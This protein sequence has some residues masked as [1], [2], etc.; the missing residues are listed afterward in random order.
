MMKVQQ[1]NFKEPSIAKNHMKFFLM[2]TKI[3]NGI[4]DT[5]QYEDK[6]INSLLINQVIWGT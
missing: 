3:F 1:I 2:T 6:E 5:M 4:K